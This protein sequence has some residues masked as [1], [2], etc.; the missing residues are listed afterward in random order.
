MSSGNW[1]RLPNWSRRPLSSPGFIGV[2]QLIGQQAVD[3]QIISI[4]TDEDS[5]VQP[6]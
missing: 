6:R 5:G 1:W 4:K 3:W 2:F